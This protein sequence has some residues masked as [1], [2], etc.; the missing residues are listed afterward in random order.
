MNLTV[1]IV[2]WGHH[3]RMLRVG[4]QTD[5]MDR[6]YDEVIGADEAIKSLYLSW[7]ETLRDVN[8]TPSDNPST[9]GLPAGLMP[10]MLLMSI[11]QKVV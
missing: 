6:R 3:D 1:S 11:A 2:M 7:P 10:A 4:A 5:D 9:D 8:T